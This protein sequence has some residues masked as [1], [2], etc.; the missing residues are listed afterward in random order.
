MARPLPASTPPLRQLHGGHFA[1][2]RALI[3]GLETR[4]SWD[5]YLRAEGEGS[6]RRQV[7]QTIDWIRQ[8]FA[9]A[10]RREQRPGTARL[11]LLDPTRFDARVRVERPSLEDFAR[12]RGLEDFS[13][14][15]Q[16]EAYE[17][18]YPPTPSASRGRGER[19]QLS[20]RA[21]VIARQLEALRWLE[22][23]AVRAPLAADSPGAW[24]A[25]PMARRLERMGLDSLERLVRHINTQGARWWRHVAGI[26]AGKA[27]RL[28]AWL[29][30]HEASI[31]L[32]LAP[33]VLAPR[34][35]L[36]AGAIAQAVPAATA[37]V[38]LDKLLV[39]SHLDGR[40]GRNRAPASRCALE[41][42]TDLDAVRRWLNSGARTGQAG[43]ALQP[44]T[45]RSYRKE[46]ERLL[47]WCVLEHQK[48]LSSLGA[49][50]LDAYF[51]FLAAPPPHW[52]G[53]RHGQ[54]WSPLW[55]PVE[56]PLCAAAIR[57]ARTILQGLFLFLV[58]RGWLIETPLPALLR[59]QRGRRS[60]LP[61]DLPIVALV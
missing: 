22:A 7:R 15:E 9:A 41:A 27:A 49:E 16:V 6:D 3:Q 20:R 13:E 18:A 48:P 28:Q 26:G 19:A 50:D 33:H 34:R 59:R 1:F 54:R 29:Q 25:P 36:D 17:E 5:R 42:A 40:D 45:A 4:A 23:C 35:Q 51:R 46:A 24:L 39:P 52:C 21:R 44:A 56:G 31:G 47:L 8:A 58:E 12:A 30:A 14:A 57:Q 11:I 37:L 53:P 32:Q 61:P 10:A 2:M 55:R 60:A 43:R 38:P